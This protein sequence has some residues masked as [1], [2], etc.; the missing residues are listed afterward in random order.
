MGSELF[1]APFKVSMFHPNSD[2]Q[3]L[4]Y[5]MKEF[6]PNIALMTDRQVMQPIDLLSGLDMMSEML[7]DYELYEK[8]LPCATLMNYVASDI[9][10]T[11]SYVVKARVLKGIALCNLGYIAESINCFYQIIDNKDKIIPVINQSEFLKQSEGSSFKFSDPLKTYR[12]DLPPESDENVA[13]V[14]SLIT[15]NPDLCEKYK[16][17]PLL[18]SQVIY[19]KTMIIASLL[20]DPYNITGIE[21]MRNKY[22]G[23]CDQGFKTVIDHIQDEEE[24]VL[25]KTKISVVTRSRHQDPRTGKYIEYL[26]RKLRKKLD[27]DLEE[28]KQ[29]EYV[30]PSKY[31]YLDEEMPASY[32]RSSRLSWMIRSRLR[33][34]E[35]H[36]KRG[37]LLDAFYVTRDNLLQIAQMSMPIGIKNNVEK[38]YGEDKFQIPDDAGVAAGSKKAPAKEEKKG[39]SK[40]D[41]KKGKEV[42]Q[43]LEEEDKMFEIEDEK[44][45]A[46]L[47]MDQK[48]KSELP[49]AYMWSISKFEFIDVLFKQSRY[50][51]VCAQIEIAK[52][53]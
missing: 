52:A 41:I 46:D 38:M 9:A 10:K 22:F 23:E 3:H 14:N 48:D 34:A 11:P 12:N 27:Y 1:A 26:R 28:G 29:D 6:L 42:D 36:R 24:I 44:K 13:T 4:E 17:S 32:R 7:I 30:P 37:S 2:I 53:E 43:D 35:L 50:D 47:N 40:K 20:K 15:V 16:I 39:E 25:L 18:N 8:V 33:I 51:E 21:D 5:R 45:W 49:C 19:L 31:D